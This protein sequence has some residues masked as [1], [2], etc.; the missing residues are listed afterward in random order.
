MDAKTCEVA[1]ENGFF[2][3]LKYAHENGCPW[4]AQ[5]CATVILQFLRS[6]TFESEREK[7]IQYFLCANYIHSRYESNSLNLFYNV[8]IIF[9]IGTKV[10][11]SVLWILLLVAFRNSLVV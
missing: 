8:R 7:I 9:T 6:V 5:R 4:N 1:A 10:I 3:C 11:L 2:D